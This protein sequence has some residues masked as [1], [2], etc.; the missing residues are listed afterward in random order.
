MDLGGRIRWIVLGDELFRFMG[1]LGGDNYPVPGYSI[2]AQFRHGRSLVEAFPT[3]VVN[4]NYTAGP[5]L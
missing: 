1:P 5:D 4:E 2:E 3:H